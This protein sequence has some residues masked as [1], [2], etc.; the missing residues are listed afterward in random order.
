MSEEKL[1]D[2]IAAIAGK[3]F[4][5]LTREDISI[6]AQGIAQILHILSDIDAVIDGYMK[7]RKRQ[8]IME[9]ALATLL[10][11]RIKKIESDSSPQQF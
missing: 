2:V 11:T 5:D 6:L 3:P 1:S 8:L 10:E 4:K 9:S 7:L